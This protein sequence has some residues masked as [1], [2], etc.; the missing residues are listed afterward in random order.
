MLKVWNNNNNSFL[1][2]DT[3]NSPKRMGNGGCDRT[4]RLWSCTQL[5]HLPI[6]GKSNKL[7]W[8]TILIICTLMDLVLFSGSLSIG[9]SASLVCSSGRMISAT[10][11][12][13]RGAF[14]CFICTG[15]WYCGTTLSCTALGGGG[16]CHGLVSTGFWLVGS[17]DSFTRPGGAGTGFW[18]WNSGTVWTVRWIW[19]RTVSSGLACTGTVCRGR[20]LARA[21]SS[22]LVTWRASR[23]SRFVLTVEVTRGGTL[24]PTKCT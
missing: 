7:A 12:T 14:H 5:S 13:G 24:W 11:R 23:S 1:K 15:F 18:D 6:K 17:T 9:I 3:S 10:W 21:K 4:W 2:T 22:S 19:G 16:G 8:P 20:L